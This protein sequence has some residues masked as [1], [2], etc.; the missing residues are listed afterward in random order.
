ML[1]E[2][3]DLQRGTRYGFAVVNDL[4]IPKHRCA[5]GEGIFLGNKARR[6]VDMLI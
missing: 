5:L 2:T 3:A 1:G 6:A 4:F